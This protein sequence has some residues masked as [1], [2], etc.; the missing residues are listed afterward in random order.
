MQANSNETILQPSAAQASPIANSTASRLRRNGWVRWSLAFSTSWRTDWIERSRDWRVWAVLLLGGLIATVAAITTAVDVQR[1]LAARLLSQQAEQT[2][3]LNQGQKYPHAAAHYGVYVFKPLSAL[4]A[5]DPGIEKYVGSSVWLEA[6]KQNEFVH[7]AAQD[8]SSSARQL[9]LT[10]AFALQVLAPL[11]I[12]FL[13]FGMF[14]SERERGTLRAL[15]MTGAPLSAVAT[16]RALVLMCLGIALAV[17]SVLAV[18]ATHAAFDTGSPFVDGGT[19]IAVFSLG[20]AIYLALWCAVT[21]W[22]SAWMRTTRAAMSLLIVVWASSA[23]ILPRIA[24]EIS[25]LAASLP[26]TQ[27]FREALDSEIGEDHNPAVETKQRL[28]LLTLY[29]VSDVKDLPVNWAG[30][31]LARG[32]A[33]GDAI[34][35]KH[36]QELFA[37]MDRQG[38]ATAMLGWLSPTIAVAGLSSAAAATNTAHHVQYVNAAETQRRVIQKTMNDFITTNVEK[39]GKRI[40]GGQSLWG[41]VKPFTFA[42]APL[43]A[44]RALLQAGMPL[45]MLLMLAVILAGLSLGR[46][47]SEGAL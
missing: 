46:L 32:E 6:H 16:A 47:R 33:R 23:L 22:L 43:S 31:S 24:V 5:V 29:G 27:A 3:W 37:A 39:N 17:P 11:A 8:E 42:F 40:D 20:Y 44:Q 38:S 13:G 19:R 14:A 41:S 45:L 12:I 18:A 4:A 28:E 1:T 34:F 15:L 21:V 36:Y 35:D 10:P 30:I 7:R 2:R 9:L 26:S 25:Q